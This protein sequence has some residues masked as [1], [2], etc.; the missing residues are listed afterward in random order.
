M[1]VDVNQPDFQ[2][3][4]SADGSQMTR[5]RTPFISVGKVKLSTEMESKSDFCWELHCAVLHN[6]LA[7]ITLGSTVV[8]FAVAMAANV[9]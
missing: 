4:V 2:G 3:C 9:A 5:V 8:C 6:Y 1:C 7:G